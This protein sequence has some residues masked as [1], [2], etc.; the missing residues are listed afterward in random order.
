MVMAEKDAR[1]PTAPGAMLQVHVT[2]QGPSSHVH[3]MASCVCPERA[4]G[5]LG[6]HN[7]TRYRCSKGGTMPCNSAKTL[8]QNPIP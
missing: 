3:L 5:R 2:A 6:G 1:L 4:G 8:Q 7:A